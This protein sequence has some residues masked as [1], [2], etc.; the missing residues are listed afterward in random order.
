[1]HRKQAVAATESTGQQALQM[2]QIAESTKR[3]A[4]ATPV[5]QPAPACP[6]PLPRPAAALLLIL[7]LPRGWACDQQGRP[8][9]HRHTH[10]VSLSLYLTVSARNQPWPHAQP[11]TLSRCPTCVSVSAQ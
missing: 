5:R 11:H 4:A 3:S 2:G 8:N 9:T 7:A 1:M 6:A 10:P